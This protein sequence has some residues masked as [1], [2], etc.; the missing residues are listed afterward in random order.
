MLTRT[1]VRSP[2]PEG[3]EMLAGK[4]KASSEPLSMHK[5]RASGVLSRIIKSKNSVFAV[6]S[7]L[8]GAR[9]DAMKC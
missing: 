8:V 7:R 3:P 4:K 1:L 5:R 2:M 9:L 6:A